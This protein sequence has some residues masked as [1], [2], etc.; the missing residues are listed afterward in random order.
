MPKE[1]YYNDAQLITMIQSGQPEQD[2]AVSWLWEYHRKKF[3]SSVGRKYPKLDAH[4]IEDC[5]A[6]AVLIV[7]QQIADGRFNEKGSIAGF[8]YVIFARNCLRFIRGLNQVPSFGS[9][10]LEPLLNLLDLEPG[11]TAELDE[12][13][14]DLRLWIEASNLVMKLVNE[15]FDEVN[16]ACREI[17]TRTSQNSTQREIAMDTNLTEGTVKVTLFKCREDLKKLLL[18]KVATIAGHDPF[19]VEKQ[20]K[21]EKRRLWSRLLIKLKDFLS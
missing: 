7:D 6:D 16:P 2:R 8:L 17:I 13:S 11:T 3:V 4:Q 1:D 9:I 18:K 10:E 14:E 5:Y 20:E 21:R 15:A 12:D 19:N